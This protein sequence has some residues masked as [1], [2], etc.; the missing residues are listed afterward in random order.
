[1]KKLL[2]IKEIFNDEFTGYVDKESSVSMTVDLETD[3]YCSP[4]SLCWIHRD[5]DKY[6]LSDLNDDVL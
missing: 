5:P 2:T 3:C 6:I 4:Y 1:M